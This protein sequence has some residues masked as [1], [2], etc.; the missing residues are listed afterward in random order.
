MQCIEKGLAIIL[1][2]QRRRRPADI[3]LGYRARA[4]AG[5]DKGEKL[6]PVYTLS[7]AGE[8]V[9]V[10][11]LQQQQRLYTPKSILYER[12]SFSLYYRVRARARSLENCSHVLSVQRRRENI[13][14]RKRKYR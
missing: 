1:S 2:R 14:M 4:R 6:V 9:N 10:S 3:G 5:N 7:L 12:K 11:P 8:F 13:A